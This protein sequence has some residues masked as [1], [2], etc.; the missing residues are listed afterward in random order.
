MK[1]EETFYI[2]NTSLCQ[3]MKA[4]IMQTQNRNFIGLNIEITKTKEDTLIL[5]CK[6]GN[7]IINCY[8]GTLNKEQLKKWA[9]RK[10]PYPVKDYSFLKNNSYASCYKLSNIKLLDFHGG[11]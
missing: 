2:K 3:K 10:Y 11:E 6:L 7:E 4:F 1:K 8:D 9:S 5:T